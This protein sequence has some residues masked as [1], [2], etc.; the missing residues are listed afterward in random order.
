MLEDREQIT[1]QEVAKALN[2]SVET[3]WR[4]TEEKIIP[5]FELENKQYRYILTDVIKALDAHQIAREETIKYPNEKQEPFTYQDYLKLP[6]K[7]GYR[8]EVLE[9]DLIKEPSPNVLHQL[10]SGRLQR[11]L[12]DYFN[13]ID[14]EGTVFYAPLDVTLNEINVVQPDLFYLTGDQKGLI[15]ET[16]IQGPPLLIVEIL[17]PYNKD[18]DR[19]R[20]FEIYQR[21]R[22]Q[23]YWIIDPD[24]QSLECFFLKDQTYALIASGVRKDTVFHPNFPDSE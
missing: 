13:E 16:H 6:D 17:S 15:A 12:Y 4:Y 14:P 22:V 1:A 9:G 23:H 18:K 10:V 3:V 20:K 7:P 21:A 8:I 11:I 19:I 24:E 2:I 5:Y